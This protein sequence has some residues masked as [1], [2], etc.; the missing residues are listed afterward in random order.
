MQD[1]NQAVKEH[2]AQGQ[3]PEKDAEVEE[4]NEERGSHTRC[5]IEWIV[6]I[7]DGSGHYEPYVSYQKGGS[8][9][10]YADVTHIRSPILGH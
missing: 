6:M 7:M 4:V 9:I 10:H 3:H 1:E 8:N 5:L 2:E